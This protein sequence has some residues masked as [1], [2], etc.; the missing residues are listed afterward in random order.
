VTTKLNG[1]GVLIT[2]PVNQAR[3]L[4]QAI[5]AAGGEPLLYPTIE[6]TDTDNPRAAKQI[7]ASLGNFD[8]A[9]F[10]SANAVEKTF[11]LLAPATWPENISAAT[12]GAATAT[13]LQERGVKSIFSPAEH[14]DS[15][16]LLALPEFQ[17][18][19]NKRMV[20]FRGQGGRETLKQTLTDRG[21]EVVYCETYRRVQPASPNNQL[22]LWAEQKKIHA[23]DVMSGESLANLLT[24]AGD[25]DIAIKQAAL[26]THHP[27][28]REM[29]RTAGFAQILLCASGNEALITVLE[30][31]SLGKL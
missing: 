5:Q 20:I 7:L 6:I 25:S 4:A 13:A 10:I 18:I 15:E 2:R 3:R 30:S 23:I 19:K 1:L 28:V 29:A 21:A 31:L 14:F 11:S 27:R 17:S 22:A 16:A 8:W 26:I 24:M 9:I 12:I